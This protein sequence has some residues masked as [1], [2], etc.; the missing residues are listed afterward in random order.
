MKPFLNT[1]LAAVIALTMLASPLEALIV[2]TP[3]RT[4]IE[5]DG[6]T[7][8]DLN[9][10]GVPDFLVSVVSQ[11]FQEGRCLGRDGFMVSVTIRPLQPEGGIVVAFPGQVQLLPLGTEIDSGSNFELDRA[12]NIFRYIGCPADRNFA[13]YIGQQF[14]VNGNVRYAWAYMTVQMTSGYTVLVT[15]TGYA[16]ETIPGLS[17][18][19]GQLVGI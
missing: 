17:I 16:Y 2:Y 8:T 14:V 5:N 1:A 11:R 3:L 12:E 15:V 9:R 4:T 13:G 7:Q 6:R 18:V 19:T 10:D